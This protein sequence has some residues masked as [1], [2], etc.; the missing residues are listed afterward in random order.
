MNNYT[1]VV[2]LKIISYIKVYIP[3]FFQK[4]YPTAEGHHAIQRGNTSPE[5]TESTTLSSF[6]STPHQSGQPI[7]PSLLSDKGIRSIWQP[8]HVDD[9]PYHVTKQRL[10]VTTPTRH[11]PFHRGQSESLPSPRAS[12]D[13]VSATNYH[14]VSRKQSNDEDE[15]SRR[16]R[17][18]KTIDYLTACTPAMRI[19]P[20]P[21]HNPFASQW[22]CPL[23]NIT[24]FLFN[25]T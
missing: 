13:Y 21:N 8:C 9:L 10:T 14:T 25:T 7:Q 4:Y 19:T 12:P 16:D 22:K 15:Q 3:S 24:L 6:V 20:P 5:A 2:Y 23:P 11:R 18:R 1:Q 17:S